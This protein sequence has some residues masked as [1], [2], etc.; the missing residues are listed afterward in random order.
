MAD[1]SSRKQL[2][3]EV[4]APQNPHGG[5]GVLI[6]ASLAMFLAVASSALVLRVRMAKTCPS[7]AASAERQLPVAVDWHGTKK[8]PRAASSCGV[9]AYRSNPDGSVS[10]QY[11]VCT[12]DD[13]PTR[14]A[15]VISLDRLQLAPLERDVRQAQRS[16][17]TARAD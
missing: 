13:A 12:E 15:T 2:T 1:R 6:V 5:L 3:Q 9:P 14:R 7:Q 16:A 17:A 4:L 8:A 11:R 10:V